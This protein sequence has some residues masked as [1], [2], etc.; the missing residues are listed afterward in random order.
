ME[1]YF[2]QHTL[3]RAKERG[4]SLDEIRDVVIHGNP[5]SAKQG[6]FAKM[7]I[8]SFEAWRQNTYYKR[9]RV[10]AIYVI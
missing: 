5:I 10:E 7:Q 3:E 8:F 1:I 6:R 4:I 2:T 9:K